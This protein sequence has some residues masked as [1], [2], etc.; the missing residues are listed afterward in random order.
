M[1][2]A[3][4]IQRQGGERDEDMARRL[5]ISRPSWSLIRRRLVP[6]TA[7]TL[8]GILRAYPDLAEMTLAELMERGAER[9]ARNEE[10]RRA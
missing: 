7:E 4:L 3:E 8:G 5:G 9:K 2:I 6:L 10:A 1:L